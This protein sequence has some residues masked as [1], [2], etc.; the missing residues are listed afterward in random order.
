MKKMFAVFTIALLGLI[1]ASGLCH[2][3]NPIIN[4]EL[5]NVK[6][7]DGS[8]PAYRKWALTP[9]MGWNS[10]DCF[11]AG[12]TET[13]ILQNA[14]YMRDHLKEYGWEYIVLDIRWYVAESA[15]YY[16][17]PATY[18]LDEW[19]RYVP[20]TVRFPNGFKS[21]ADKIHAM[22]LKFGIHIMRGLPKEAA[23]RKLPVKGAN[24]VTCDQISNN[25]MECPWL[26]DNYK[27]IN[28]ENGQL[29][30]NSIFDLYAEWGVDFVKVDDISRP[31]HEDEIQMVRE[32]ID[33][34]G[35]PIV[36][37]LSPG[38]TDLQY[39]DKVGNYANMWRMTD[40]LWDRWKDIYAIFERARKWAP[41]CRPGCY[42]DADMIP[43]GALDYASD[44]TSHRYSKLTDNEQ[45]TL[46][47]LWGVIH[48][49]LMFGG[50]LPANTEKELQLMT[51]RDLIA[52][53]QY[54]VDAREIYNE[55]G[56]VV[57]ASMNPATGEHYA[58]LFNLKGSAGEKYSTEGATHT[59]Q[60]IAYT[61]PYEDVEINIPTGINQITLLCDDAEDG[62]DYDHGDWI[63]ARFVLDNG[64]EVFIT[65]DDI[66]HYDVDDSFYKYIKINKNLFDGA[67]KVAG[68]EYF[69]GI[70][71]H[72]HTRV[73]LRV[74]PIAGRQVVKFKSRC[75]VDASAG[76]NNATSMRFMIFLF[77][78]TGN[79][80][81]PNSAVP[82]ALPLTELGFSPNQECRIT[83][84][85]SKEVLGV[86]KND[87]FR[88]EL[89]AH[90]SGFYII[91]P[92]QE[93]AINKVTVSKQSEI[94]K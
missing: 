7:Q 61:L 9:P 94:I 82:V 52:M 60:V 62:N 45:K 84:G 27:V 38:K 76:G 67:L 39:A 58:C 21:M 48:S 89:E 86:Y 91:T 8:E 81:M 54:G 80:L 85:W 2:A 12:A 29:Y 5:D 32:A 1:L 31:F 24:G 93:T 47:N 72:A 64:D 13:Q 15:N 4:A 40:D 78:P 77:D 46:M 66:I 44:F 19:G 59:T 74:P 63:N 71:C 83:D 25:E 11:N 49:P 16:I 51:N 23:H 3:G 6:G 55:S 26:Q 10:W 87:E 88:P 53:N 34:S 68:T 90:Q 57:W 56:K 79:E 75:G 22:G 30:Y 73:N 36:L 42:P 18:S 33:R 50:N 20:P 43:I 65:E 69:N 35:R 92:K 14:E 37:S 70:A 17:Q 41:Y 28:N